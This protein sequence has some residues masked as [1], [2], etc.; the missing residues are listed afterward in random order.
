MGDKESKRLLHL[1]GPR[2]IV[3]QKKNWFT[4]EIRIALHLLFNFLK[5]TQALT[6]SRCWVMWDQRTKIQ[7]R[8]QN[9]WAQPQTLLRFQSFS[10][11]VLVSN[12]H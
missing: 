4:D 11:Q 5:L 6:L 10:W 8:W 2:D 9:N 12:L 3:S 1:H 7:A